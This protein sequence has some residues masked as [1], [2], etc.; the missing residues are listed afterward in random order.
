M[1]ST[2]DGQ[3]GLPP[4][5]DAP[6]V[7]AP[8]AAPAP[9][10]RPRPSSD[11]EPGGEAPG[12]VDAITRARVR[13][14]ATRTANAA[15]LFRT[16]RFDDAV[17]LFEQ[18]L[19]TC[20]SML[21]DDHPDTMTVAGNLGV[22]QFSAGNRRKGM[23]LIA[24]CVEDRARVVGDDH[25]MTLVARDAL[26]A[27]R[28]VSGDADGAVSLAQQVVRQRTRVLGAVHADTFRSRMSLALALAAAGENR[29]AHRVLASTMNDAERHLGPEHPVTVALLECGL[30]HG[31]LQ[32][33]V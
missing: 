26:A 24:G 31:L 1:R 10:P 9:L 19:A 14:A 13:E 6:V 3:W 25:P 12:D 8:A 20:R 29:S 33:E 15:H 32:Q 21:G 28:R 11:A 7:D 22:A 18:A 27:A 5:A 2:E 16:G 4:A 17:R 23:K 30:S